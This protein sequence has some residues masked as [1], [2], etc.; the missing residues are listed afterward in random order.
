MDDPTQTIIREFKLEDIDKILEI[1]RHGTADGNGVITF[2]GPEALPEGDKDALI[3]F[4]VDQA[5][6]Q[7]QELLEAGVPGIHIYTMDRSKSTV[8]I[9]NRLREKGLL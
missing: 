8:Q 6:K 7:C 1:E 3:E 4:G 2:S 5:T 9:V